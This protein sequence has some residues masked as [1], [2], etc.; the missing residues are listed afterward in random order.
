MQSWWSRTKQSWR[1]TSNW[2]KLLVILTLVIAGANSIYTRFSWKQFKVM[3]D[4]LAE[5]KSSGQQTDKLLGLYQQQLG[6]L[7]QQVQNTHDLAVQ[8]NNQV[9]Q[10]KRL[11]DESHVS[12]KNAVESDRPWV[13]GSLIVEDFEAGKRATFAVTTTNSGRR[14]AL[15]TSGSVEG[16][17]NMDS[18]GN[19]QFKTRPSRI[20]LLPGQSSMSES[21]MEY[22]LS[23]AEFEAIKA[24][25][26]KYRIFDQIKY[27]DLRTGASYETDL[28]WVFMP[29][30]NYF[31]NC[32]DHNDAK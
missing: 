12:N 27:F 1:Q 24:N 19:P 13:G 30:T 20:L 16:T 17:V 15:V 26:E 31:E 29:E 7:H 25:R 4:Q 32:P 22:V 8:A 6:E 14:P 9:A 18:P 23:G 11:A 2:N 10:I 5:M 3:N 21:K 28:C